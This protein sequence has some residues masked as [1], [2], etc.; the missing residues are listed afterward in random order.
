Y[1]SLEAMDHL[2][3]DRPSE[4]MAHCRY[5]LPRESRG[6]IV[7]KL[8]GRPDYDV[9][10]DYY[11]SRIAKISGGF[12]VTQFEALIALLEQKDQNNHDFPSADSSRAPL[13]RQ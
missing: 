3:N 12:Y 4:T 5:G 2:L 10:K 6:L 8:V 1:S 9:L 11:R 7:A 13:A